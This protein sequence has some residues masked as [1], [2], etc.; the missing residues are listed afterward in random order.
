MVMLCIKREQESERVRES[1]S[2]GEG[3][4]SLSYSLSC[5]HLSMTFVVPAARVD[6]TYLAFFAARFGAVCWGYPV[7]GLLRLVA[8]LAE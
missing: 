4:Y 1:E 7:N 8:R 2:K 3:I 6:N 5:K